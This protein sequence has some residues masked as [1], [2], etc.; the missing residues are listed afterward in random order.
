MGALQTLRLNDNQLS[1][2]IPPE[3]GRL[4]GLRLLDLGKNQLSGEIAQETLANMRELDNLR[5]NDN[6]FSGE[7]P[8]VL[9]LMVQH[10]R[11]TRVHV[12]GN[13][14]TGCVPRVF[15]GSRAVVLGADHL[16]RC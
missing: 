6:G 13:Q 12:G 15:Q 14:F 16:P 11:L 9:G 10:A 7:F 2:G 5:I 1:G 4:R 8:E 3:L